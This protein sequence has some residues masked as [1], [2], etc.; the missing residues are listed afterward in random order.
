[1][2][3][4]AVVP[5]PGDRFAPDGTSITFR[6]VRP[7]QLAGLSVTG[8]RTGSHAGTVVEIAGG[9]AVFVP[10][11]PFAAGEKV[12]VRAPHLD[13]TGRVGA[14]Y[15]FETVR[16][17]APAVARAGLDAALA[18]D[19][20]KNGAGSRAAQ[21]LG[22]APPVCP[23]ATYKTMPQLP[24]QHLCMNLGVTTSGVQAGTSLFLTPGDNGAGIYGSDGRL[25]WWMQGPPNL[26]T[27]NETVVQYQG[28]PYLAVW[29]GAVAAGHGEG[30]VLLYNE[31][32]QL[33]G[34]LQP[35]SGF[36][37]N[38]I[39]LHEFQITPSGDALFGLYEPA[40]VVINGSNQPVLQYVV[41]EVSLVTT[42]AGIRTGAVLFEWDSLNDVPTSQSQTPALNSATAWD[43]F[44]GNAV[45]SDPGGGIVVSGRNT[46]GIYKVD[47]DP[48]DAAFEHVIWQVGASGDNQLALPWCYQ[49]DV[50]AL[51]DN[52]YSV[53]D[54]G[55]EGPGCLPGSTEHPARGLIFTVD[56]SS[57]PAGV[58]L[59]A[60]YTHNPPI[61]VGFTGSSQPL[62]NGDVLV[63]WG[64][65][66]ELTEFSSSGAVQMD[67]SM[68]SASYRGFR[69]AWVGQPLTPPA[70][71]ADLA[72]GD[73]NVWMSWNGATQ[74]ASWRVLGGP[75][76]TQ[77]APV[78]APRSDAS[79]ETQIDVKGSYG[80]VEAQALGANG[81]VLGT[82]RPIL[83]SGY[84]LASSSGAVTGVGVDGALGSRV[85]TGA[86]SLTVGI[87]N[88]AT[89]A[90]YWTAEANGAVINDGGAG[91]F[92]SMAGHHL[93][94][95][96]VSI[97]ATPDGRGYWLAAADGGI[98]AFGDA[99]FHGS[100]ARLH[101]AAPI[102]G[103][104]ATPDGRGY[105]LVAADGGIFAFGDARFEGSLGKR[106]LAAPVV[107]V[108]ATKD[109]RGYWLV[110]KD[111]TVFVFGDAHN[112]GSA[113]GS[114]LAGHVV[115][116]ATR[117]DDLGYW[118][119]AA[120]GQVAGF[121]E[122]PAYAAPTGVASVAGM[123]A[124][125]PPS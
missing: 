28:A 76:V 3:R 19:S 88:P 106:R 45:S 4:V 114:A 92:G 91:N 33:V 110:G 30:A 38:T 85:P 108:T 104:A 86:K 27:L 21:R 13:V 50:I 51:G 61:D 52:K 22:S 109:G 77:L 95:P 2:K 122:A 47:D 24:V 115:G 20:A 116:I 101:L 54:D 93:A 5:A 75:S 32:Y 79:F 121:G 15:S 73:T 113:S 48:S 100:M 59:D 124:V 80:V 12:T 8:S 49:H 65:F 117:P 40:T 103:I 89:G 83:T 66:P 70:A 119:V 53:F 68:S 41:Q 97:A 1:V 35:G 7:R 107:G 78:G 43:Y 14:P 46:W 84:L 111:G 26:G 90:G 18:V 57:D 74:V 123:A 112:L 39:D 55:G 9:G 96:I 118:V 56:P 125:L 25:E 36:S 99:R 62:A 69:F 81:A 34:E 42:T 58:T 67:L 98:F 82:S 64:N 10:S 6:G 71:V 16:R 17:V 29:E 60:S 72:G 102:V 87:A 11:R 44:H 63:D 37:Q 23:E 94:A 120:T 31:H 105:W